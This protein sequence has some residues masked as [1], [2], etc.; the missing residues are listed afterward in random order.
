MKNRNPD[1]CYLKGVE[2]SVGSSVSVVNGILANE[3]KCTKHTPNAT[4]QFVCDRRDCSLPPPPGCYRRREK[5]CFSP[6]KCFE[7]AGVETTCQV[8]G[9]VYKIG[10]YFEPLSE[11]GK[12]CYCGHGYQG[13]NI[14]PFCTFEP[15]NSCDSELTHG[16]AIAN[17]CAPV[18]EADQSMSKDC[19]LFFRCQN[20]ADKV[21]KN[22][23]LKRKGVHCQFGN[24]TMKYGDVLPPQSDIYSECVTCICT[25][26]PAI[27]C[28]R[29]SADHC[30]MNPV[31]I[32]DVEM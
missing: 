14:E 8:D 9:K 29:R 3:C 13:E 30:D 19:P 5:N 23:G 24:L 28:Q 2:Y 16:E 27:S 22:V 7:V 21:L 1:V 12:R 15:S 20:A 25:M 17:R 6:V 10:E 4:A 32:V 11:P 26:G 31:V 18:Y